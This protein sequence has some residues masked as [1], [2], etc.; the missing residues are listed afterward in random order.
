M[1]TI[2]LQTLASIHARTSLVKF[3]RS[4]CADY[5]FITD[6]PNAGWN[7]QMTSFT[8]VIYIAWIPSLYSRTG[9]ATMPIVSSDPLLLHRKRKDEATRSRQGQGGDQGR[10]RLVGSAE[11]AELSN[12]QNWQNWQTVRFGTALRKRVTDIYPPQR[13]GR[14]GQS[15]SVE[16]AL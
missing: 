8:S 7:F 3:A 2:Y 11:L 14:R 13:N 6:I 9:E 12:Y 4:P 1:F 16:E 15:Y 10:R 5:Y